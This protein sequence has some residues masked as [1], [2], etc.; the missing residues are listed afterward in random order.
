MR[1]T[2]NIQI[3]VAWQLNGPTSTFTNASIVMSDRLLSF[4]CIDAS[5]PSPPLLNLGSYTFEIG[6]LLQLFVVLTKLRDSPNI[7]MVHQCKNLINK[8]M[9]SMK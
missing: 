3:Y 4:S 8:L 7:N 9:I 2:I 1:F 5:E 6:M